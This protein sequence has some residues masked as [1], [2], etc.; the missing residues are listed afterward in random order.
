MLQDILAALQPKMMRSVQIDKNLIGLLQAFNIDS[1][2]IL[3][4]DDN[5]RGPVF[6]Y[7]IPE[8]ILFFK[9]CDKKL[10]VVMSQIAIPSRSQVRLTDMI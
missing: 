10:P 4:I 7:L 1:A 3:F 5:L 9:L 8:L 6:G 2:R